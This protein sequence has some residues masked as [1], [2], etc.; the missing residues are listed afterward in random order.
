MNGPLQIRVPAS[1]IAERRYVI[2]VLVGDLLF[3][4]MALRL[5]K[6]T[7]R[8]DITAMPLGLDTPSTFGMVFFVL[9]PAFLA[10]KQEL[11]VAPDAT[12]DIKPT[13]YDQRTRAS[14]DSLLV[15]REEH[16]E[17]LWAGV[18]PIDT[19]FREASKIGLPPAI[20]DPRGRGVQAYARLL[21]TLVQGPARREAV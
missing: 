15:L 17:H 9:G 20:F 14:K 16:A 18:I 2:G 1:C 3:F 6:Q 4:W 12:P 11:G 7:G 21:E 8:K 19:H 13:F 5:A 10:A